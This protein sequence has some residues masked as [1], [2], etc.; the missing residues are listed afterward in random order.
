MVHLP[1][2]AGVSFVKLKLWLR[3]G[4]WNSVTQFWGLLLRLML[5]KECN[6]STGVQSFHR[7][8]LTGG[9][10]RSKGT[11]VTHFGYSQTAISEF[12]LGANLVGTHCSC[13]TVFPKQSRSYT[14]IL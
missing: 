9:D 12:A 11:V 5:A 6:C 1:E 8:P 14:E 4:V 3:E 7:E 2:G 13:G 10:S